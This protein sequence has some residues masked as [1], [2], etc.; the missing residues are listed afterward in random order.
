[1]ARR[2]VNAPKRKAKTL[3]ALEASGQES[4][5]LESG[6]L[7][8]SPEVLSEP[9]E[10]EEVDLLSNTQLSPSL[11]D[12]PARHDEEELEEEEDEERAE[13]LADEGSVEPT[14]NADEQAIFERLAPPVEADPEARARAMDEERAALRRVRDRS[15]PKPLHRAARH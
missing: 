3:P 5:L 1:M 8:G 9:E 13:A 12:P 6:A 4:A 15:E 2:K 14:V 11:F 7:T 10:E